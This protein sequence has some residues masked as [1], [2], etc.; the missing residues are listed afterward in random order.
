MSS[1]PITG[2]ISFS[3]IRAALGQSSSRPTG[4]GDMNRTSIFAGN[5]GQ[6]R[7]SDI[8]GISLPPTFQAFAP[9]LQSNA[10]GIYSIRQINSN[11]TGPVINIRRSSD[12]TSNDFYSDYAGNLKMLNGT[13]YASW[14]N[15]TMSVM[16][17][18]DQSG[19]SRHATATTN[20]GGFPPRLVT[21]P[22]GSEKYCIYFPNESATATS[23]FGLSMASQTTQAVICSI[24][25]LANATGA[26]TLLST[27]GDLTFRIINNTLTGGNSADFLVSGY[28]IVNGVF[29]NV[30]PFGTVTNNVWNTVTAS[31]TSTVSFV[32]LGHFPIG[33][34][35]GN[36]T[37]F[38]QL[39]GRSYVGYMSDMYTFG[40]GLPLYPVVGSTSNN[41]ESQLLLKYNHIP[42]WRNGLTGLYT[43]DSWSNNQWSD[44]SGAGNHATSITG[45]ITTSNVRSTSGV[46]GLNYLAGSNGDRIVFPTTILPSNYT[47]FHVTRYNGTSSARILSGVNTNWLSGHWSG[48]SGVAWHNNW[49]TAQSNSHSNNWVLSTDQNSLYRSGQSNRTIASAG[50]PSFA[51]IGVN[52]GYNNSTEYS[53]WAIANMT[54]YN[55]TLPITQYIAIEDY[56][57]SKYYLPF[58]IQDG[59]VC[60]LCANDFLSGSTIWVD[61][62]GN[63]N[64]FTLSASG[65]YGT[66]TGVPAMTTGTASSFNLQRATNVPIGKYNTFIIFLMMYTS[67][68]D[69]RTLLRGN[70]HQVI[71]NNG[72]NNLGFWDNGNATNF[73]PCDTNVNVTT[74]PNS[75]TKFNMWAFRSSTVAPFFQFF[76]NPAS[77]PLTPTGQIANNANAAIKEGIR[78][79]GS[80]GTTQYFGQ[81]AQFM[82]YNRRLSDAELVD[83]YNRYMWFYST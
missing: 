80:F 73:I 59:L 42:F 79:I 16:A 29:S 28:G 17:W 19:G 68:T 4:L 48:N 2:S 70:D 41:A 7:A 43:G 76:Y 13:G 15:G 9:D 58:P 65:M 25:P 33:A 11:Y 45:T 56:L 34:Y 77:L 46:G 30:S 36:P 5:T 18:Y 40:I 21:D 61:R 20:S 50:T 71:I 66:S 75:S 67:T 74:L 81:I 54:V 32:N 26:Q 22:A 51:N 31:S 78:H 1:I 39:Q 24:Y 64:N 63:G 53:Q 12:N 57:A 23:Y 83:I 62:T 60:S 6:V 37:F 10:L 72:T 55:R 3:N 52:V 82:Q 8:R 27:T 47:L 44:L 35:T 14:S 49:I 38:Q 69:W